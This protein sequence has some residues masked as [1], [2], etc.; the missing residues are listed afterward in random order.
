M[1]TMRQWDAETADAIEVAFNHWDDIERHFLTQDFRRAFD[2][3]AA[4]TTPKFEGD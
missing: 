4:K 3:L 1:D 2:A